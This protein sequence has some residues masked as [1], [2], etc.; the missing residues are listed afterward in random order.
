MR[1]TNLRAAAAIA[2]ITLLAA[3]GDARLDKLSLGISADSVTKAIGE[4]PHREAAYLMA[5]KQWQL[6]FFARSA[7]T[8]KDSIPWRKMSPVVLI[9]G[10]TVGWGWHWWSDASTKQ[11]IIMPK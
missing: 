2:A 4:P 9:D 1:Q 3:C 8:E 7:A 10:K 11:G 6:L 5:G